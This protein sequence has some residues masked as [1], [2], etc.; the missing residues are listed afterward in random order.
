MLGTESPRRKSRSSRSTTAF[1]KDSAPEPPAAHSDRPVKASKATG[2]RM[3]QYPGL[4]LHDGP[5]HLDSLQLLYG[6]V[7]AE[8]TAR[9]D[10]SAPLPPDG[11]AGL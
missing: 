3:R 11:L 8:V 7:P 1:R 9:L 5:K 2:I 4:V 6:S 10:C